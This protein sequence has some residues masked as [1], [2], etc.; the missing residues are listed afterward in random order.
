[1][2]RQTVRRSTKA[3][4]I[5]YNSKN[6]VSYTLADGFT[7]KKVDSNIGYDGQN[8]LVKIY[9]QFKF[10]KLYKHIGTGGALGIYTLYVHSNEW[11]EFTC[12]FTCGEK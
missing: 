12:G 6:I 11:Y 2:A 4:D 7:G 8:W 5:L 9:K 10:A 1:M 3:I